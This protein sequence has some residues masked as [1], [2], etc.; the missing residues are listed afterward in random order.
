[1]LYCSSSA[2]VQDQADGGHRVPNSLNTDIQPGGGVR[3]EMQVGIS[4]E[5][6]LQQ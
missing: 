6:G 2:N 5:N 1:M 3:S 4:H